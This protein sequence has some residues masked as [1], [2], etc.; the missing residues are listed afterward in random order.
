MSSLK[1]I[2]SKISTQWQR[3]TLSMPLHLYFIITRGVGLKVRK[4]TP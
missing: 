4:P 2:F 3:S 1:T